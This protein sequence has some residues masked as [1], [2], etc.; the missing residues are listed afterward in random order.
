[1][2]GVLGVLGSSLGSKRNPA[3]LSGSGSCRGRQ[4][5][6]YPQASRSI[7]P[8]PGGMCGGLSRQVEAP[9]VQKRPKTWVSSQLG[10]PVKALGARSR[11]EEGV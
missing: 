7:P 8:V 9:Q 11:W 6:S 1:M 3:V 10:R 4:Q 2:A 5:P